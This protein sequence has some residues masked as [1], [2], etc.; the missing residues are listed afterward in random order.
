MAD[1]L[2]ARRTQMGQAITGIFASAGAVT[3]LRRGSWLALSGIASADMNMALLHE[4]DDAALAQALERIDEAGCPAIVMLAGEAVD[5]APALPAPWSPVGAMPIMTIDLAAAPTARDPR[6]RRA[7]QRDADAACALLAGAYLMEDSHVRYMVESVLASEA[8]GRLWLLVEDGEPVSTVVSGRI[9]DTVSLWSMATPPQFARKGYG[10]ALLAE[11]LR[12]ATED[13]AAVG[14][15][16]A[17]PAGEPLY[18]AS[19]WTIAEHWQLYINA[20][21]VQ[22]G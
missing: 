9:E 15:L 18:R 17:T 4:R 6:V 21:S 3:E 11:V 22:F 13:G 2:A 12:W 8:T 14:L 1:D 7:R 10:R 16:G 5:L 19:G 20:S